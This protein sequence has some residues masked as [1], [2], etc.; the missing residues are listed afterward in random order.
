MSQYRDEFEDE[1]LVGRIR[2]NP[3]PALKWAIPMA[4]LL[5]LEFGALWNFVMSLPWDLAIGGLAS[6]LPSGLA[7]GLTAVTDL[8]GSVGGWFADLW[9][10]LDRSNVPNRGHQLPGGGWEGTFMGLEPAYAWA[11]RVALTYAYGFVV[12]YWVWRGYLTFR[13]NYRYAE[14]TP[15]DDVIERMRRHRWGQ[16]G[17]VIVVMFVILAMFAP[18]LGPTT[19]K[20]NIYEPYQHNIEYLDQ[21]TGEVKEVVIGTANLYSASKG[22]S[23]NYGLFSYDDYGRWHPLGTLDTGK[24]LFTF[25]AQGARVSLFIGLTASLIAGGVALGLALLTAYY[26]GLYDLVTVVASDSMVAM[27]QLLVLIMLAVVLGDT[28]IASVYS[29]GLLLALIFGVFGWPFLWRAVRG[30]AFQTVENEWVDAAESFG[31]KPRVLVRKHVMPYV[32]GYLLIYTSMNLGGYMIGT[33]A[34]SY[35]GLGVQSPTPEW[36]RAI[37]DGQQYITSASWHISILPGLAITTIVVGFN[38]LG[39]GI[40]DAIDPQSEGA[41]S[42]EVAAAG[43]GA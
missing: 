13:E 5:A 22:D 40:R 43:G 6:N 41:T 18:T 33:A 4:V 32:L 1:P 30:P 27:P 28:W 25:M 2:E 23:Q 26:K 37:A 42:D 19:A 35:L 29:G 3:R 15:T 11:I 7:G 12:L 24:D 17:L 31:Q 9:T 38:A 14:W 20:E 39:D 36:G 21:D 8:F 16:F 34:L 10:L